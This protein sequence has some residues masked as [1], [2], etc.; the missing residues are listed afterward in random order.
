MQDNLF[1]LL[2]NEKSD[3]GFEATATNK[4]RSVD[5]TDFTNISASQEETSKL[6]IN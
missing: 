1:S 3:I 5:N 4:D 2:G 6:S